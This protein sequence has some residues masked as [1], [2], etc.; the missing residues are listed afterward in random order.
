MKLTR[1]IAAAQPARQLLGR[2]LS[3]L[4]GVAAAAAGSSLWLDAMLANVIICGPD[5]GGTV[6]HWGINIP[7]T[8]TNAGVDT[9]GGASLLTYL[10]FLAI[11]IWALAKVGAPIRRRML[12][13]GAVPI[14]T[15]VTVWTAYV[16]AKYLWDSPPTTGYLHMP[17]PPTIGQWLVLLLLPLVVFC[18]GVLLVRRA[19]TRED[20]ITLERLHRQRPVE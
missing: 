9:V 15:A 7:W 6:N 1:D 19:D 11:G 16:D 14:A 3:L 2:W 12:A 8:P 10:A 20:Q 5:C 17:P 4:F 18:V 13:L